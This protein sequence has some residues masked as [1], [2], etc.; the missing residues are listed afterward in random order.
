MRSDQRH[1]GRRPRPESTDDPPLTARSVLASTLL[2]TDPPELP[3]ARLVAVAALFGITENRARVALTRMVQA[4]EAT[5]D[6]GRYRLTGHLA[7]RG[8]R[9]QESRRPTRLRWRGE[10]TVIVLGGERRPAA[11]RAAHRRALVAARLA[12][13]REGVWMRPDNLPGDLAADLPA[14]LVAQSQPMT[15]RPDHPVELAAHLW[16]L[17]GWRD[18]ATHLLARLDVDPSPDS[19]ADGFVLSASVLRHLQ[20]DPL[21]PAPLVPADWNGDELRAVYDTWDTR[22]RTLLAEWHRAWRPTPPSGRPAAVSGKG[23]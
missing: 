16:D 20:A 9:Q 1:P 2:G 21:L 23:R 4:G 19:L 15:A 7:E 18:H 10:W 5:A 8:R 12:E 11:E 6:A 3:V 22:Y 13:L 14:D 17:D